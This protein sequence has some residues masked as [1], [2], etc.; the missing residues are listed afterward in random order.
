MSSARQLLSRVHPRLSDFKLF[1]GPPACLTSGLSLFLS[2]SRS[3]SIVSRQRV[4]NGLPQSSQ[5]LC[6]SVQRHGYELWMEAINRPE[7]TMAAHLAA[8]TAAVD[9]INRGAFDLFP[10]RSLLR[11]VC[12]TVSS[13]DAE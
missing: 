2:V 11:L 12:M 5:Q 10:L 3:E 9:V 13:I 4:T 7:T 1:S 8:P 6:E